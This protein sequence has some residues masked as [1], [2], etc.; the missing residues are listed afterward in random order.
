TS[1]T[2]V[3]ATLVLVGTKAIGAGRKNDGQNSAIPA[4]GPLR[5]GI[6]SHGRVVGDAVRTVSCYK[7][8]SATGSMFY[9]NYAHYLRAE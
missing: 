8:D 3:E 4:R 6:V 2:M 9:E 5:G 7:P 1:E